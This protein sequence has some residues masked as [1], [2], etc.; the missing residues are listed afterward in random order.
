METLNIRTLITKNYCLPSYGENFC[1]MFVLYNDQKRKKVHPMPWIKNGDWFF[2]EEH[3]VKMYSCGY[4]FEEISEI[5]V[6]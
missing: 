3:E 2:L 5:V 4:D 1:R 6:E